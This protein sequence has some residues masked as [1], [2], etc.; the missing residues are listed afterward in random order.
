MDVAGGLGAD[1]GGTSIHTGAI[2]D[3]A[4]LPSA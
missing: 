3:Y 4:E 1:A 2:F